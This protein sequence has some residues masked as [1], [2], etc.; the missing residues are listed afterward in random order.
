MGFALILE[1]PC[2][3][4]N[5]RCEVYQRLAFS[6]PKQYFD[7]LHILAQKVSKRPENELY[8]IKLVTTYMVKNTNLNLKL[9]KE[10]KHLSYLILQVGTQIQKKKKVKGVKTWNFKVRIKKLFFFS[11]SGKK[12]WWNFCEKWVGRYL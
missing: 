5:L 12:K 8:A 9:E 11:R 3:A 4:Y 2:H 6:L 1:F 10:S 7:I